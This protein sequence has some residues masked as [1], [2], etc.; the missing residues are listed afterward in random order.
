MK[1]HMMQPMV[2]AEDEKLEFARRL[3][4]A[5]DL[6]G[7]VSGRGRRAELA[8]MFNVSGETARKWLAGESIPDTKRIPQ[9][10]KRL[11]VRGEWLLTGQ[12][13]MR[14]AEAHSNVTEAG[15]VQLVPLIS[16]VKAGEWSEAIDHLPPGAAEE[17][18]PSPVRVGPHT[19]AL[20]VQGDSMTSPY[21]ERSYPPGTIIYVD[22]DV[23]PVSG[24]PVVA[25]LTDTNE[26]TFKIYVEEPSGRK[27]LRPLNPQYPAI[28]VNS[29]CEVVGVVVGSWRPE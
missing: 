2:A 23:A 12:G 7:I 6:A 17:W 29:H 27:Y 28:E 11:G 3:H 5:C 15:T 16:W 21:G 8:R 18:L 26:V 13:P 20:R 9:I 1:P 14:T 25:K 24:K 19:F 10:A 22:P 4:T